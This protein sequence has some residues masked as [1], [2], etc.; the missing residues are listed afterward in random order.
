M[1]SS[2]EESTQV[3]IPFVSEVRIGF[4]ESAAAVMAAA[5]MTPGSVEDDGQQLSNTGAISGPLSG[6][7]PH[8]TGM[9]T[10]HAAIQPGSSLERE[11]RDNKD[12]TSGRTT[13]PSSPNISSNHGQ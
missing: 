6:S 2:E 8:S 11:Q 7:P 4:A 9:L 12:R 1:V 13:P 10:V 3:F 5:A